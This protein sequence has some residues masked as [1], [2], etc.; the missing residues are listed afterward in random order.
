MVPDPAG[1]LKQCQR[2]R[3]EPNLRSLQGDPEPILMR[4]SSSLLAPIGAL[5]LIA[6]IATSHAASFDCRAARGAAETAICVDPTL[7]KLDET[8]AQAYATALASVP[9]PTLLRLEQ[10]SWVART[11]DKAAP[12]MLGTMMQRRV[13][14]LHRIA[15]A[16]D[17]ARTPIA[18][19]G[20]AARCIALRHEPDETC[21][22]ES[23]GRIEDAPGGPLAWQ[24]VGYHADELRTAVGV[25]VLK[26]LP[27]GKLVPTVW[28]DAES[29]QF[30]EPQIITTPAGPLLD[31]AGSLE[32]TGVFNAESLYQ[33]RDSTWHE[34]D[35]LSW[36]TTLAG[37][38]P[39]DRAVWK[40]VYPDW[41][42]MTA[43]TNLWRPGDGNCCPSGGS[44]HVTLGLKDGR[45]VLTA[46]R[47]SPEPLP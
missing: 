13:D 2:A 37:R 42:H 5:V 19:D 39:Q 33:L 12:A 31:L 26:V 6:S 35:A 27:D 24:L 9:R 46:V 44:A 30:S 1:P 41:T 22:V 47:L 34:V 43:E 14:A 10:R 20:L 4:I 29:A 36:L 28:D 23:S 18:P 8:L 40:G 45:I 3:R 21:K 17:A 38:L 25:V 11:R 15:A 7:S 16:A 32:G